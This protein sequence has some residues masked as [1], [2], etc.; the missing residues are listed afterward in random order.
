MAIVRD[1]SVCPLPMVTKDG[2]QRVDISYNCTKAIHLVLDVLR[3]GETMVSEKV[4]FNGGRGTVDVLLPAQENSF[5]A[6]WRLTDLQ[7]NVQGEIKA[8]WTA[9]RHRTIYVML[10]SH[11][12][13]G[14]HESQYIQK[15]LSV[16]VLDS[17]MAQCDATQNR[18]E[19]DRYRYTMEGT[20]FWNNYGQEKGEE[21]ARA[22]VRDYIK[23]G[24]LGICC[25]IAGNHFQTFD[26]EELCRAAG[27]RRRLL[28][29][30]DWTA[31]PWPSSTSTASP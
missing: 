27:E 15:H 7:G 6:L 24:K 21:A 14:L 20:W 26:Q 19:E 31:A 23:T 17:A 16:E 5:E 9:P 2:R 29:E 18:P 22:V 10:S 3:D 1:F 30:W 8:R 11:V 4:V 28:E 12:D 13:I 25:G